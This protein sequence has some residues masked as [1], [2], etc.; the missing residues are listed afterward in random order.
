M[1]I[2][3]GADHAGVEI[4]ARLAALLSDAGMEVQD[5]GPADTQSVDYPDYAQRVG[6]AVASGKAGLG[7][8]VCGTGIG[9][10]IA[11]NKMPHIRAAK[12]NDAF[13]AKMCRRHNNA[14]V[15]CLGSRVLDPSV[16]DNIALTFIKE[17]FE[18]G[19]HEKRVAKMMSLGEDNTSS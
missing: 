1:I 12:C 19:R 10:S 16:M 9:M 15:L 5:C 2:A 8:L 4:K 17:E 18:G 3:I 11:A 13:E 7:I 6:A 14:N